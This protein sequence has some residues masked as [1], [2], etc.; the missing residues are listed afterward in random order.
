MFLV[1]EP[2][3]AKIKFLPIWHIKSRKGNLWFGI[4][5]KPEWTH[6]RTS[7]YWISKGKYRQVQDVSM[8]CCSSNWTGWLE[9]YK[10]I[11]RQ[12][13]EQTGTIVILLDGFD[14]ISQDFNFKVK[15]LIRAIR[16]ET[17]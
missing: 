5:N 17:A 8:E 16:D 1:A 10:K 7:W 3:K 9:G 2:G 13:L 15:K 12:A 14:E 4:K 11:F 6:K